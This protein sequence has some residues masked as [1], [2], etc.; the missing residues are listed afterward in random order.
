[1][2]TVSAL[3]EDGGQGLLEQVDKKVSH[4]KIASDV[5]EQSELRRPRWVR[6]S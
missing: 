5:M 4:Q 1:V 6:I 2:Q 3:L